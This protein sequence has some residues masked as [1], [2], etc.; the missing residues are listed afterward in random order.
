M[1]SFRAVYYQWIGWGAVASLVVYMGIKG[2]VSWWVPVVGVPVGALLLYFRSKY[3]VPFVDEAQA[4][5]KAR[6]K[7]SKMPI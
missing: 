6:G 4:R 2:R 7:S 5:R 1:K 3:Y